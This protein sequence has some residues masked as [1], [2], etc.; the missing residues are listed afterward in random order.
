MHQVETGTSI[1]AIDMIEITVQEIAPRTI[2]T[3]HPKLA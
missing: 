2:G 3:I 1:I